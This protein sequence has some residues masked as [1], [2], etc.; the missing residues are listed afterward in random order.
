M[1]GQPV[2]RAVCL[3]HGAG[4]RLA[5]EREAGVAQAR[6][7]IA[8]LDPRSPLALLVGVIGAV[9]DSAPGAAGIPYLAQAVALMFGHPDTCNASNAPFLEMLAERVRD[10]EPALLA[11]GMI[12]LLLAH[13]R[14]GTPDQP[15]VASHV[16]RLLQRAAAARGV[17]VEEHAAACQRGWSGEVTALEQ[18]V[19]RL[20]GEA[21]LI[22]R[23]APAAS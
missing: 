3:A 22:P 17:P 2:M 12:G 1:R 7:A 5:R 6:A 20:I 19:E 14:R 21:W 15:A 16:A 18:A 13:V 9:G 8:L 11:V 23:G 10:D 4:A